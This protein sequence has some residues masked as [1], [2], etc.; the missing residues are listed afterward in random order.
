MNSR[1]KP[2]QLPVD[3]Y[4]EGKNIE[5]RSG[6]PVT[7]RGSL[8]VHEWDDGLFASDT[9]I[10]STIFHAPFA[11]QRLETIIEVKRDETISPM[12]TQVWRLSIPGDPVLMD[13]PSGIDLDSDM[14]ISFV[15]GLTYL[16]ML[17]GDNSA[18]LRW[19]GDIADDWEV[20]PAPAAADLMPNSRLGEYAYNRLWLVNGDDTLDAGDLL[21]EAFDLT[22]N[23]YEIDEGEAG[24]ILAV[25]K[26]VQ[27]SLVVLKE[28]AVHLLQNCNTDLATSPSREYISSEHG[29]VAGDTAV[30]F[31][32]DL[33]FLSADGVR[34]VQLT[35]DNKAQLVD[36]TISDDI[37]DLI[38]R[39]NWTKAADAQAVVFDNY[40]ILAV[41]FDSSAY[42][43]T[44]LAF[45][46]T[47]RKW[48][49]YWQGVECQDL[50]ITT[51]H[52]VSKLLALDR[53]GDITQL[54]TGLYQDR[55]TAVQPHI[56][57][58]QTDSSFFSAEAV[59]VANPLVAVTNG[60]I[61]F[62]VFFPGYTGAAA[63]GGT[64]GLFALGQP[65]S[66]SGSRL[67]GTCGVNSMKFSL[68]NR[69]AFTAVITD[70]MYQWLSCVIRHNGTEPEIWINGVKQSVTFTVS[71][72]KTEWLSYV[73]TG[74]TWYVVGTDGVNYK[75]S[76][77]RWRQFSIYDYTVGTGA[78]DFHSCFPMLEGSGVT[79]EEV[80]T[81]IDCPIIAGGTW[82]APTTP[83]DIASAVLTRSMFTESKAVMK[84]VITSELTINIRG[85]KFSVIVHG[86]GPYE[87]DEIETDKQYNIL[88]Y[89]ISGKTDYDE[90]GARFA[91][92]KRQEY[93]P[94]TLPLAGMSLETALSVGYDVILD[95]EQIHTEQ[96]GMTLH[97]AT[98]QF[99]ITNDEG[100][101]SIKE[102]AVQ[103][104]PMSFGKKSE[105]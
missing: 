68:G 11:G 88:K 25:K 66:G 98:C 47:L 76:Y 91:E 69:W 61:E 103:A 59:L 49:G 70:N 12:T 93:A 53:N 64:A 44:I 52:K 23:S 62:Q 73:A 14:S 97:C 80:D 10:A 32:I 92:A 63:A 9:L 100:T 28:S 67:T 83:T 24:S 42:N 46:L 34:S 77:A 15:Q 4:A 18:P 22:F 40:Y 90:T 31:G 54:L 72:D 57:F 30:M 95:L 75:A 50:L 55:V 65:P 6:N 74:A 101:L 48:V 84:N 78:K 89:K 36:R 43:D 79:I 58:T 102:I 5:I 1:L 41:P 8:N 20:I 2:D 19:S 60:H 82:W 21:S 85:C 45:D 26:F 7:R 29:T 37:P 17:R 39:I 71:N 104:N 3:A 81:G 105:D 16:Y 99:E 38:D 51:R 86:D 27:G 94:V 87:E 13:L 56:R 33:W 35:Q 96:S